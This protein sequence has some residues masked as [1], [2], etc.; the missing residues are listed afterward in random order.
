MFQ[1]IIQ[2]IK[3]IRQRSTVILMYHQVCHRRCDPWELAVHPNHFYDQLKY[4]KSNFNVLPISALAQG[5]AQGTKKT[6]AITFDDGFRDN[7]INAAPL[8]DWHELPA[9]FYVATTATK[10]G[11]MYWWDALQEIV[12]HSESLPADFEMMIG[13]SPVNFT[14]HSDRV[15]TRRLTNQMLSW[16][17]Q[18]PIPNERIALYMQLWHAIKP[19]SYVQQCHIMHDIRDWARFRQHAQEE[20]L[21][22]SIREMQM[23][24]DNPLFSIG[25]HSVHHA[26]L[27]QQSAEDQA[28]EIRESKR[29]IEEWTGKL[30]D[31]FAYPYGNYSSLTQSLLRDSGFTYAVSTE[32]KA[33][34]SD[35][36]LFAL[37]RI[38][39]KNWCVYEFA[40]KINEMV[41]E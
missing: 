10:E 37:P 24:G 18:L 36:D 25:A 1:D 6:V 19:L 34:T 16:N 40:S 7:Y 3:K 23:L 33:V 15:L 26:M 29:Q 35:D 27:S 22:M 2:W 11:Q 8:L 39:V 28:F 31:G 12:F 14:F 5:I 30:V 38:Q 21:P 4:L 9:T 17:S 13:G 41:N 20:G 32:P